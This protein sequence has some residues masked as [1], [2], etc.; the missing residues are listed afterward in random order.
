MKGYDLDLIAS[1]TARV[2]HPRDRRGRSRRDR[3]LGAAVR[4]GGAAAVAAGAM[5]VFH[6]PHRAVLITYPGRAELE[7]VLG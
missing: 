7:E 1:V 3:R 2:E 5:F 4:E 6:G